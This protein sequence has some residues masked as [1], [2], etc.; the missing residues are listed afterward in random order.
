MAVICKAI[1]IIKDKKGNTSGYVLADTTGQTM[2]VPS[3]KI[4]AAILSK[5]VI[6]SNLKV[7]SNNRL[8][9]ENIEIPKRFTGI[10]NKISSISGVEHTK[11]S[12]D[13][14]YFVSK[15][16]KESEIKATLDMSSIV[17]LKNGKSYNINKNTISGIIQLIKGD[18]QEAKNNNNTKIIHL[19][20]DDDK[21]NLQFSDS[22]LELLIL[23]DSDYA[24]STI[25]INESVLKSVSICQNGNK[26][27][28]GYINVVLR[29]S[30]IDNVEIMGGKLKVY[31]SLINNINAIGTTVR[32]TQDSY[33]NKVI[34]SDQQY[35]YID[36]MKCNKLIINDTTT[37]EPY[38]ILHIIQDFNEDNCA[39]INSLEIYSKVYMCELIVRSMYTKNIEIPYIE[40]TELCMESSEFVHDD[41]VSLIYDKYIR[42][43]DEQLKLDEKNNDI[44]SDRHIRCIK[45]FNIY[46]KIYNILKNED[47]LNNWIT[48]IN[49]N[50]EVQVNALMYPCTTNFDIN[51][52]LVEKPIIADTLS[53][54]VIDKLTIK[55]NG[56]VYLNNNTNLIIKDLVLQSVSNTKCICTLNNLVN[57]F[58]VIISNSIK[59]TGTKNIR[60][61]VLALKR[62]SEIQPIEAY[63]G[64][65]AYDFL[66][67]QDIKVNI[68]NKNDIDKD[69]INRKYK[70]DLLG[71][72]VLDKLANDI[73]VACDNF[74]P[75][76]NLCVIDTGYNI[77]VPDIVLSL[78]NI[79][80]MRDYNQYASTRTKNVIDI[81]KLFD[82]CN[83]PF[84]K[85]VVTQLQN[86]A[87]YRIKS[88]SL[89]SEASITIHRIYIAS[90][91]DDKTETYIAVFNGRNLIYMTYMG[92]YTFKVNYGPSNSDLEIA[93]RLSEIDSIDFKTMA[94][95][96]S[97]TLSKCK[98][99]YELI[100]LINDYIINYIPLIHS[101]NAKSAIIFGKNINPIFF[102]CSA[103]STEQY[104]FNDMTQLNSI[105]DLKSLKKEKSTLDKIKLDLRIKLYESVCI[106][107]INDKKDYDGTIGKCKKSWLIDECKN[108]GTE[109][110]NTSEDSIMRLLKS[111][112][113]NQI[114]E[115]EFDKLYKSGKTCP[116]NIIYNNNGTV[117]E[118]FHH[119]TR[120]STNISGYIINST[121]LYIVTKDGQETYYVSDSDLV[122]LVRHINLINN[123]YRHSDYSMEDYIS[124]LN[125][126]INFKIKNEA[127][128]D[129][130]IMTL[131]MSLN[132][133]PIIINSVTTKIDIA[134]TNYEIDNEI[135]IYQ[136]T[137]SIGSNLF[138]LWES[139]SLLTDNK[140]NGTQTMI[141]MCKV[142]GFLYLVA[143]CN[144][145]VGGMTY[146][147]PVLRIPDMDTAMI[148]RKR[149]NIIDRSDKALRSQDGIMQDI[150]WNNSS[151]L[152]KTM[153]LQY[154]NVKDA[155]EY[156]D[157][158]RYLVSYVEKE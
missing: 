43:L 83:L 125:W 55:G 20:K 99:T 63:Y 36:A 94:L 126:H 101:N 41:I 154:N 145:K 115:K 121:F 33:A 131:A 119:N 23:V 111:Y 137:Q 76:N 8:I 60:M 93:D 30:E 147:I 127:L 98:D 13:D 22:T 1:D 92:D 152:C 44:G 142:T 26:K 104:G 16:S 47:N 40:R 57:N 34:I 81:I 77:P 42:T 24:H 141:V 17:L 35:I 78:Y 151:S 138:V 51:A 10:L 150:G 72:N 45:A 59:I 61:V 48:N 27:L 28:W 7:T 139:R 114:S 96:Q 73:K 79:E 88:K 91:F 120:L 148:L 29:Y 144:I 25:N 53:S 107:I 156:P 82:M 129:F 90:P 140:Q 58:S 128:N 113:F 95:R 2:S 85:E 71:I 9:N 65:Q 14:F 149:L 143:K 46:N 5:Q 130:S 110:K 116:S 66:I 18:K 54:K 102:K 100:H 155:N 106:K 133:I 74:K 105:Y 70:E 32:F 97:V 134:I 132:M 118:R 157:K 62:L 84:S 86:G 108:F 122:R 50:K 69:L 3:D 49:I 117:I 15:F 12:I 75:D 112:W 80:V 37:K 4:K 89:Y 39:I 21:A 67:A 38:N 6:V 136:K 146:L 123:N 135:R 52:S 87:K 153:E 64:T 103:M 158:Y 68:I 11:P 19:T 31:G 56:I 124:D 109:L